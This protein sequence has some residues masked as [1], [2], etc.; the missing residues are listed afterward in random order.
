MKERERT[1]HC[2]VMA[3]SEMME[4]CPIHAVEV[5]SIA[6]QA[7]GFSIHTWDGLWH[8]VLVHHKG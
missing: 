5:G 4:C 6:A 3:E 2:A 1:S 7:D 8:Q